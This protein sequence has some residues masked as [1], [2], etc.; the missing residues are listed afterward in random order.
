MDDLNQKLTN[1]REK[2]SEASE[3]LM[4]LAGADKLTDEQLAR[5]TELESVITEQ[6]E[7]I[8][9]VERALKIGPHSSKVNDGLDLSS[10]EKR[11]YSFLKLVRALA[12][13][14]ENPELMKG[15]GFEL[16][17]SRAIADNIEREPHGVYIPREVWQEGQKRT[18]ITAVGDKGGYFVAEELRDD[19]FIGMLRNRS[20]IMNSGAISLPGL[21]GDVLLPK[22]SG[23]GSFY[24]LGTEEADV[25][26]STQTVGQV[27]LSPKHGAAHTRYS[28]QALK[29]TTP[30]I[31]AFVRND[32]ARIM[33]L[34]IDLAGL[35]GTGVGGQPLG[36]KLTTNVNKPTN[37]AAATPTW[38]ELMAM[39]GAV[40][41]DNALAEDWGGNE[42]GGN[43]QT[44]SWIL[45]GADAANLMANAKDTGSGQFCLEF[46]GGMPRIGMW[47][48]R[49]S[50]QVVSGDHWFGNWAD[51]L[52]GTWGD[53]DLIVNPFTGDTSGVIRLTMHQFVD[54][55]VRH[56][57]SFCYNND[58]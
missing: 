5:Y 51:F 38:A 55:A 44:V 11:Q 1:A 46:V 54:M 14:T 23:A 7:V 16:E 19:L 50:N 39:V 33:A 35:Y 43:R 40:A 28:R 25:S 32:L 45:G 2:R 37:F 26:E 57:E 17:C 52:I 53:P 4:R 10:K 20:S 15:I 18:M 58:G 47:G 48:A 29:Q 8:D 13:R 42:D 49:L 31:E 30:G 24:W 34:G 27:R 21:V 36:L 3:E 56:A 9:R 12:L 41:A 22:Q 6:D